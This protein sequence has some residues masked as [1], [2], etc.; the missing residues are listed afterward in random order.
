MLLTPPDPDLF[1]H[2]S[3]CQKAHLKKKNT[4][5]KFEAILSIARGVLDVGWE[6]EEELCVMIKK[7]KKQRGSLS[8][9]VSSPL[10]LEAWY[11]RGEIHIKKSG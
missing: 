8:F 2:L 10:C 1:S 6:R 7:T 9:L 11:S 5:L 3:I 4:R